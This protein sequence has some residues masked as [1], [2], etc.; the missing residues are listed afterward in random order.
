[1]ALQAKMHFHI[2]SEQAANSGTVTH[3]SALRL[4]PPV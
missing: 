1:M 3:I 2:A 4:S